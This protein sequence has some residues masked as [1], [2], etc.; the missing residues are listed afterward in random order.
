[1]P[2]QGLPIATNLIRRCAT[3][4]EINNTTFIIYFR[5]LIPKL[6]IHTRMLPNTFTRMIKTALFISGFL[7][8]WPS[9]YKG[10]NNSAVSTPHFDSVLI[11]A[12][13]IY[14]SGS[15]S[16]S[17]AFIVSARQQAKNLSITDEMN[18]FAF[19]SDIYR[20]YFKDYDKCIAYTDTMITVLEQNGYAKPLGDRLVQAYNM[21]ADALFAKGLYN[22]SYDYYFKAKKI[23]RD[24]ADSCALNQYS[25]SLGMAL[26]KQQ[27]FLKAANHFMEAW[28][29][30]ALCTDNFVF[31]YRRQELLDNI[32]LCY[33]HAQKYDSA[34]LFYHKALAFID[35][36][37]LHYGKQESAYVSA[38][39]VVYGNMADIYIARDNY[40]TARALLTKSI[41]INLRKGY[42]NSDALVDQVKLANLYFNTGKITKMKETLQDIKTELDSIP[43][44]NVELSLNKLMWHYYNHEKDPLNA[45]KYL[46]AYVN[47]NDSFIANTKS[48]MAIDADGRIRNLEKQLQ[49]N[50]LNKHN[51]EE[52]IYLVIA[53]L[54]ALMALVIIM[55]ILRNVKRSK[56]NVKKLTSLNQ[57]VNEQKEKLQQALSEL[58]LRDKDKSRILRSVAHDVMNPIT[59]VMALTDILVAESGNYSADQLELFRLI[60]EACANSLNLS[61]DII[62]AAAAIDPIKMG[63]EWVNINKLVS[64]AVELLHFRAIAKGQHIAVSQADENIMAF[65]NKD[66]IWR[67]INNLVGNAIKFSHENS[68]IEITLVSF[69]GKVDI[70]VKDNGIGIPEKNKPFV[71]NIFSEA[72]MQGTSGEIPHGLGLSISMQIARAHNGTI[73]FESKENEG[74]VFHLVL[75]LNTDA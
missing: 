71:F 12:D 40:D 44:K 36:N 67:V 66:K 2:R 35:A 20:K 54:I 58:E 25:Y 53:T 65:V 6:Y 16:R 10:V 21:K 18:Y 43:D 63:K 46:C 30:A 74:S 14:D 8:L 56:E 3:P 9:C 17:L 27:Q 33:Y 32:G 51:A 55:L 19:C 5:K 47:L 48:L 4:I 26:Y 57:K 13:H 62:E 37:Y 69:D 42:T 7:F 64:G 31:F 68:G 72:K 60:K 1:M 22:E 34:M 73:W 11:V 61:K 45:Y 23:A 28:T 70:A 50:L 38:K 24:I 49:I 15:A 29:E 75:P 39:A 59:A 41:N 52:R